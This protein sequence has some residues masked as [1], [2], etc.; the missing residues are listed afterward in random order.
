MESIGENMLICLHPL[1]GLGGFI[2]ND[3]RFFEEKQEEKKEA[4]MQINFHVLDN[5]IVLNYDRKTQVIASEDAR[6]KD[7][8]ACIRENRLADIPGVVEIEKR[9]SGNGIELKDGLFHVKGEP[10]PAELE[11]RIIKFRDAN[12]PYDALVKFW[13]NLKKNPSFNSRKMLFKFLEHNGHPLTTDGC[14]IAYRGVTDDFKDVRTKTFDNKPGSVCEMDRSQVDENPNNT[15]SSGLHVACFDYAKGFGPKLIE[16]KV[17]PADVVAVPTD[18]NGTK[19]RVC[20]FEVIQEGT[21]IKNTELEDLGEDDDNLREVCEACDDGMYCDDP[22]CSGYDGEIC[23]ECDNAIVQCTCD[24]SYEGR[25]DCE[26][27]KEETDANYRHA[28]RGPSGKFV[29]S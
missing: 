21:V 16:V 20:R 8:L 14:F 26:E 19:M 15:C 29:K 27:T 22:E 25:R 7:V 28:K 9:Y 2:E 24:Q 12:L 17:N 1:N 23:E 11:A 4:N 3:L 13:E 6:Y 5:S 10:M 18:Y